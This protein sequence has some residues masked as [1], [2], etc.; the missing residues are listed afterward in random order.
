MTLWKVNYYSSKGNVIRSRWFRNSRDAES[1]CDSIPS[2]PYA[3]NFYCREV[4]VPE[5]VLNTAE[6]LRQAVSTVERA[7]PVF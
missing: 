7:H 4:L 3:T 5:D 2:S 6:C 1:F